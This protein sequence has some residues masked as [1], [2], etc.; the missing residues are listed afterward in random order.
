MVRFARLGGCIA[1]VAF[2]LQLAGCLSRTLPLPPPDIDPLVAP[3][4]EGLVVVKGTAQE[5]AAV[6]VMNNS[7]M[8]GVIVTSPDKGCDRSCR[9]QTS[10]AAKS[11]DT[12]HIWQFYETNSS[13]DP[14]VPR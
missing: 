6:G 14:K 7:T 2:G 10:I 13:V 8:N 9:F 3:N 12:L 5:G 1:G 4:A 11:G